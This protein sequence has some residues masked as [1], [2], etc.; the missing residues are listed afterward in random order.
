MPR[1]DFT[2]IIE[3]PDLADNFD[4]AR[5]SEVVDDQTGRSLLSETIIRNQV[6]SVVPGDPHDLVRTP[7][8][9][10]TGNCISVISR[11]RFR[12]SGNG[13]QPDMI[14]YNG[15]RFTVKALKR[16]DRYGAGFLL[17]VAESEHA[18]DPAP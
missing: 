9:Q 4:V 3:D 1:L 15:V 5:R 8:G 2:D 7:E 17:V 16:W 11:F 18:A 10:M 12:A 13:Y 14:L 6:G